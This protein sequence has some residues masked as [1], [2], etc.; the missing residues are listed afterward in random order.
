ME[1]TLFFYSLKACAQWQLSAIKPFGSDVL[2]RERF[3]TIDL[4]SLM[5]IDYSTFYLLLASI[6]TFLVF[7]NSSILSTF[8]KHLILI[9]LLITHYYVFNFCSIY[10]YIPFSLQ[11]FLYCVFWIIKAW[12]FNVLLIFSNLLNFWLCW[13]FS[14]LY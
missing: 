4:I 10:S 13:F 3:L 7:R 5:L 6:L 9:L 1:D 11:F 8:S 2:F 12:V 14:L